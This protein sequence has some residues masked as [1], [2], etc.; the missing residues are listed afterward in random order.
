MK[1]TITPTIHETGYTADK[2]LEV[3]DW[4]FENEASVSF[5]LE[6]ENPFVMLKR[7]L[8]TVGK[9]GKELFDEAKDEIDHGAV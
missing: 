1:L 3:K 8:D 6:T 2:A 9:D 7:L 4:L 5:S